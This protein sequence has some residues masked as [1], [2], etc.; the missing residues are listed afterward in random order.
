MISVTEAWATI[1]AATPLGRVEDVPL[2][3]AA[4]RVLAAPLIAARTQPP[5][6]LSAMDGYAVRAADIANKITAFSVVGEAPA[7]GLFEGTIGE[8][9]AVRIFTGAIVPAG[10]DHI[11]IQED[12]ESAIDG[13][14]DGDGDIIRL[15]AAQTDAHHIRQ[16]G[17][18]FAQG[19]ELLPAGRILSPADLAL[20]ANGNHA[21]LSVLVRP[22]IALIAS[23]D[24]I[25]P[26]G[27]AANDTQIPDSLSA[28]LAAM[29]AQWGGI[30]VANART[31]DDKAAFTE[32]IKAL[33][34]CDVI[35]PIG[36]ASVGDY[37][38]AKHVFYALGFQPLFEKIAVK[39][40]KPC[41]F[42]KGGGAHALGL[43][44]NPSSAMVTAVLF[45]QPLIA[46]LAGFRAPKIWT[47]AAL[48]A[49]LAANG[50]REN[51]LRGTYKLTDG[52]VEV[53]VSP[54]QDSALTTVFANA[55]CL[56]QRPPH[57]AAL[58]AGD[59]VPILTL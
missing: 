30:C 23:G 20:A 18:D 14:G 2:A 51:Y 5:R 10:A 57:A 35:V 24:E 34:D 8:A 32:A 28:A 49:P 39:P 45:L 29:I 53:E 21:T 19:D 22:R 55:N 50:G 11:I 6:A 48:T 31:P 7:G 56:V 33:P 4:R 1:D 25:V 58:K 42:A 26:A 59:L 3:D 17:Q 46:Q 38:Y 54:R 44:G 15:T 12:T 9:Q 37:D 13:D 40:G 36:G 16:A 47:Q 27:Q 41:W 52:R 43:P